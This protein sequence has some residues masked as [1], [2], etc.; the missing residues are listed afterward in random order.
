MVYLYLLKQESVVK[1]VGLTI[2]PPK[3][4]NDHRRKKPTHEFVIFETHEDPAIASSRE[5][6]MIKAFNTMIPNGWNLSPGG[7]YEMASGYSR[8]GIG[9][10]K[11]GRVPWN[12]GKTGCF[13]EE[14]ISKMQR[15][16]KGKAHTQKFLPLVE[17]ILERFKNH[18]KMSGV[19]KG[20]PNGVVLTQERAFAKMYAAEYGMSVANLRNIVMGKTWSSKSKMMNTKS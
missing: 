14:T 9:G 8:K 18:P 1:Y 20:G 15:K 7:E 11:K 2:N 13:S 5:R 10:A 3:R 4:K 12:K 6:E 19:G 16:R 17:S